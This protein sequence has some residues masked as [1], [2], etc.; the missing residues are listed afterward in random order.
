MNP[1]IPGGLLPMMMPQQIGGQQYMMAVRLPSAG[2][3]P[4]A[5]AQPYM[6]AGV[7]GVQGLQGLP[8]SLA[9]PQMISA[10]HLA[11]SPSPLA[12]VQSPSQASTSSV[13]TATTPGIM[14]MAT[15]LPQ[16]IPGAA[17]GIPASYLAAQY[18]VPG[19]PGMPGLPGM[20]FTSGAMAG[21][22]S[23]ASPMMTAGQLAA[24]GGQY[25][26]LTEWSHPH[27]GAQVVTQAQAQ[28]AQLG[29]GLPP[30]AYSQQVANL[31][32]AQLAG[33][34]A[35]QM[36]AGIP[37]SHLAQYGS[38]LQAS[39]LAGLQVAGLQQGLPQGLQ[40]AIPTQATPPPA[41]TTPD[42]KKKIQQ[43]LA[44]QTMQGLHVAGYGAYAMEQAQLQQAQLQQEQDTSG[45][46]SVVMLDDYNSDLNLVIDENG[47]DAQPLVDP[48]GFCFCWSGVRCTHG[49]SRGKAYYE[50]KLTEA[51]PVDFGED[52]QET[53]PHIVRVGWSMDTTSFQLGEE[54]NSYG[55]GGTGK[56][57]TSNKFVNYGEKFGIGDVIGCLLDLDSRPPN[58]SYAKNG[59]WL[60]V[61]Q[62]LH[63]FQVGKKETSLFPHIL[64]KNIRFEVNFGQQAPW[65][66]PAP[67]FMYIM[68]FPVNERVRGLKPPSTKSSCEM[69][70]IIGLPGSGKTTWG[71]NKAKTNPEMRYNIIG[72]DTLID[73]MKVMGL[74]RKNNYHGRWDVLIDK[75]SKCLNKLFEI[76]SKKK[77]NLILDQTNVYPSA[78]RRKMRNFK[79]FIRRAAILVPDDGELKRRSD[80][81]T[82]EDGKYVPEE[83]VLDMK[84]NFKLPAE[85]DDNF[86]YIEYIELP[87]EKAV[88]LVEQY[89]LE[90]Q[91]KRPQAVKGGSF[92]GNQNDNRFKPPADLKQ[93]PLPSGTFHGSQNPQQRGSQPP[94]P[95]PPDHYG[96]QRHRDRSSE[97]P[98]KRGRYDQNAGGSALDFIKQ[99]YSGE[100]ESQD[101]FQDRKP[102]AWQG[103]GGEQFPQLPQQ[104][105]TSTQL[106]EQF[107]GR[108]LI[109]VGAQ[110]LLGQLQPGQGLLGEYGSQQNE[111]LAAIAYGAQTAFVGGF[112]PPVATIKQE[113]AEPAQQVW[114]G[115]NRGQ[116]QHAGQNNANRGPPNRPSQNFNQDQ[117]RNQGQGSRPNSGFGGQRNP[118]PPNS[119]ANQY[120]SQP[121][122]S[123][124]QRNVGSPGAN[125][126][127]NMPGRGNQNQFNGEQ[128]QDQ[129]NSDSQDDKQIKRERRRPSKWDTPDDKDSENPEAG[130]Q[131][132]QNALSNLRSKI[133]EQEAA[134]AQNNQ[135][136]HKPPMNESGNHDF[137]RGGPGGPPGGPNKGGPGMPGM[138][139]PGPRG[140]PPRGMNPRG[141]PPGNFNGPPPPFG[142]PGPRGPRGPGMDGPPPF[143]RG[144]GGFQERGP[145]PPGNRGPPPLR[146]FGPRGDGDGPRGPGGPGPGWNPRPGGPGPGGPRGFNPRMGGPPGPRGPFPGPPG[147]FNR[148]PPP[149]GQNRWQRP[150]H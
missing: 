21:L 37:A 142:Q 42:N 68:Q 91:S 81:R 50:C 19:I 105:V 145:P 114:P 38:Q 36:A 22:V 67:G 48:P 14:S 111:Q 34:Q 127:Q 78:R 116:N 147:R 94:P 113:P 122:G 46:D 86:D 61:A 30:S 26:G 43:E 144:R 150:P 123:F 3:L 28:A 115:Q 41:S 84:A 79:G 90:G 29:S 71:I 135:G 117:N 148:P 104:V 137:N 32:N 31:A 18:G 75:A 112:N 102:E 106:Q 72:T 27:A 80:K 138:M 57:A 11:A 97:P 136:D 23:S 120:G 140:P 9:Q 133:A 60:G 77:R 146:P 128:S 73:K 45:E 25:P 55:Y 89:N 44:A 33:L 47:Y 62:P 132:F 66:P 49:V 8:V 74:P 82:Y 92:R 130:Q 6:A 121:Q 17:A 109:A 103:F 99:E 35:Q 76:A 101:Q 131:D 65:F 20:Q 126:N 118:T 107:A 40:Q 54:P 88:S 134:N 96:A 16:Q 95:P 124:Q 15:S 85:N 119:R 13:S 56:F 70:M 39:G 129:Q 87:R 141:P 100:A 24:A 149:M 52:H 125:R 110:H 59:R 1:H 51:L 53:N 4:A 7:P 108:G 12:A 69:I 143:G 64:T 10:G 58:M 83:A 98:E 2:G 5:A 93:P 139:G 63:G